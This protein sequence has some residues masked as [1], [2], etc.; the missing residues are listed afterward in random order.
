MKMF[1]LSVMT[2]GLTALIAGSAF[3]QNKHFAETTTY[4]SSLSP[5]VPTCPA[6]QVLQYTKSTPPATGGTYSCIANMPP[7]SCPAGSELIKIVVKTDGTLNIQASCANLHKAQTPCPGNEQV[8]GTDSAGKIDCQLPFV[9]SAGGPN[10][11]FD[12]N[13]SGSPNSGVIRSIDQ[14]TGAPTCVNLPKQPKCAPSNLT[15]SIT[16]GG[17]AFNCMVNTDANNQV[18]AMNS[19]GAASWASQFNGNCTD[20]QVINSVN[21]GGPMAPHSI[22]ASCIAACDTYCANTAAQ[23]GEGKLGGFVSN[24]YGSFTIC[25]CTE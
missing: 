20:L 11:N 15:A 12:C 13:N 9:K 1:I 21:K 8:V 2:V 5:G 25:K 24:A 6:G 17:G 19:Y 7:G 4:G 3:A 18:K 22:S 10:A 16:G 23:N 14:K